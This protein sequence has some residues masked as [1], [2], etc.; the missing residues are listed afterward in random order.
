MDLRQIA[1]VVPDY[2]HFLTIDELKAILAHEYA[3]FSHND[4]LYNRFLAQVSLSIREARV[5]MAK[6]GGWVTLINPFYWCFYLYAKSYAMLSAGFSRS[7]EY[8]ADRMACC[9]F[10]AD[11]FISARAKVITEGTLFEVLIFDSSHYQELART[12][13]ERVPG[14]KH[15]WALGST[16]VGEDL[17]AAAEAFAPGPLVPARPDPEDIIRKLDQVI[18]S[19]QQQQQQNRQRQRQQSQQDQN[20]Q[21]QPNQPQQE[22][23]RQNPSNNPAQDRVTD[24][25]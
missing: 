24:W 11:V 8:L 2:D 10:G 23:E 7:R 13:R 20:K 16:D 12:V 5:G 6:A 14:L 18:H 3:H 4:T 17:T 22:G 19:A 1:A 15:L 25:R 9:L 21:Q